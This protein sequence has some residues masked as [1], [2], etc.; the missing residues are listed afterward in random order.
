[1]NEY[2]SNSNSTKHSNAFVT[3]EITE[4][5]KPNNQVLAK[6]LQRGNII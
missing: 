5:R 6:H 2:A 1:M 4:G 3:E